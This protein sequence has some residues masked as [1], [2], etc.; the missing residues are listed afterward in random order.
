MTSR[1]GTA[2][3]HL[4]RAFVP[5][6]LFS[7]V[8]SLF[9]ALLQ[10][11]PSIYMMQVYDRVLGSRNLDTLVALS[12]L[13]GG[14]LIIYGL[15]E[16]ARGQIYTAI[17]HHFARSITRD[18]LEASIRGRLDNPNS[19]PSQVLR[20]IG[21]IRAFLGSPSVGAPFDA[22]AAPIFFL[23][24][25]ILHPAFGLVALIGG[26]CVIAAT[27]IGQAVSA[28]AM[29]EANRR[30]IR[31]AAEIGAAARA[32]EAIEGMGMAPNIM[33]RTERMQ[34]Q[35][36]ALL[37]RATVRS[38]TFSTLAR[39]LRMMV[40]LAI[41]G[42][43]AVLVI[44]R[45]VSP[46]AMI[47]A[48]LILARA[49][50]PF[51]QLS[52]GWRSW[53]QAWAAYKRLSAVL[54]SAPPRR[55]GRV[56]QPSGALTVERLAYVPPGGERA[57]LRNVSFSLQPGEVL[58]VVGPS[59][60]GKSTLA[61]LLVGVLEPTSGGVYLD[62]HNVWTWERGD[63]GRHV[64]YV[65]QSVALL[66][67]TIAANIA[68]MGAVDEAAVIAAAR[69]AGIHEMI[70]RLPMGYETPVGEA[71][72]LL[73]GGQRQRLAL[74]RALYG[75]P[76]LLVLDEPNANLDTEGENALADAIAKAKAAG[77][78]VVVVSHR[79]MLLA[80][81][82]RVMVLRDGMID[83]I[84]S[85]S[86]VLRRLTGNPAARPGPAAAPAPAARPLEQPSAASG[87]PPGASPGPALNAAAGD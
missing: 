8:V 3:N 2:G 27:L 67:G 57:T 58:G 78:T 79:P 6:I 24:L 19:Q 9:I 15:I 60:A 36:L 68:R 21:E 25:Y 12:L 18:A 52:E 75:N 50:G 38:K 56:P 40:Q 7:G 82:D 45:L 70:G 61:R 13:G 31:Q 30:M 29:T 80:G 74:A 1:G 51:E 63:F 22:F 11:A 86:D 85:R 46:G 65:P 34:Q 48:S 83:Q 73:S 14:A 49:V 55:T 76:R 33:N 4:P 81:A 16:V 26:G 28:P 84:G 23:V 62:G 20:D 66:E 42:I 87:T 64:G 59:A 37:H 39:V 32:A 5:A 54:A 10:L 71:G 47:V 17:G 53:V 35:Y 44:D 43:G 41:V 69:S 77:T 72:A